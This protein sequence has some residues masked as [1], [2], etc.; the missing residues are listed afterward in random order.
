MKLR[1]RNLTLFSNSVHS[2]YSYWSVYE[3]IKII[4]IVLLLLRRSRDLNLKVVNGFLFLKKTTH[5][6]SV[7]LDAFMSQIKYILR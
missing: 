6:Q 4:I 3:T 7:P 2:F 1:E 5:Q